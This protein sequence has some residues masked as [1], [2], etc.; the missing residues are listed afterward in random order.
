MS[1]TA[2]AVGLAAAIPRFVGLDFGPVSVVSAWV[3]SISL[4]VILLVRPYRSAP[5]LGAKAGASA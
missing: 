4:G 5:L 3:F 1:L 2:A